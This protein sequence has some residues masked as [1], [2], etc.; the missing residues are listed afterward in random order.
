LTTTPAKSSTPSRRGRPPKPKAVPTGTTEAAFQ[1][2]LGSDF[3]LF[4]KTV[5]KIR[6]KEGRVI[7]FTFNKAQRY[8]ND[9]I[10]GELRTKGYFRGLYLKG[11]QQGMSTYVGGRLYQKVTR[12]TGA[13]AIVVAHVADSTRML[14][15]MTTRY[16]EQ[17]PDWAKPET[18]YASRNELYFNKLDG[19]YIVG[20]AG[21][22]G[23][24]RGGTFQYAHLSEVAFWPKNSA[25]DIFNGLEQ[26][27]PNNPGT[28]VHIESTANGTSGLFYDL[29]TAAEKGENDYTPIF[30][31]WFWQD[32]YRRPVKDT[33]KRSPEEMDIAAEF[34]LDDEQLMFR[35][36][37]IALQGKD[38]FD[39]EYPLS[40]NHAFISTGM[41]VF[42]PKY[43]G[44]ERDRARPP[45][46]TLGLVG[47]DWE[48]FAGGPLVV[49]EKPHHSET[50]YI[51]ADVGM[52]MSTSRKDA[53]WSVATVLDGMKRVVARYRARVLPDNFS[54]VLYHIGK[55]YGNGQIIVENNAH[56]M[57]TCVR[58]YK[59]LG[60][61]NFYTEEVVDKITDQI[62]V[63]LGFTTSS[64]S[65]TMILNKLRGDMRDGT[66]HV[67]DLDTL[68]E[69]RTF[70]A[71]VDGKFSAEPGHHDDT[72]MAL[73][74]ANFIHKGV[75][76]PVT[77]FEE[78]LEEAI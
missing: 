22:K 26:A 47:E 8:V 60:Y 20:T 36:E 52:G 55:L 63:R 76:K 3:S 42:L 57:L 30:I 29:W 23:L 6:T 7:P 58:L 37:K 32:E 51:G 12:R 56:G 15:D 5:L 28:E 49:W 43:V 78:Y 16:H 59:D 70:V 48:E 33:F 11:R 66:I 73:A 1:A 61:T 69:M 25:A 27:I 40:P 44:R 34:G 54:H 39:Q 68:D 71:T 19:R 46:E 77:D 38:L 31:P 9:I 17:S 67:N 24:G 65:K 53:D 18:R 72:I 10:E 35:R 74:L 64:K 62:T 50:Y 21:S 14:F 2:K 41:A 75:K 4:A 13:Q 45:I